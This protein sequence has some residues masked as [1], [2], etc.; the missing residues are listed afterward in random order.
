MPRHI[1]LDIAPATA[2]HC[3]ASE[4]HILNP[5]AR[6]PKL[7]LNPCWC[8]QFEQ[9][10]TWDDARPQRLPECLAAEKGASE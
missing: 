3:L 6:C 7:R 2:T 9:A 5:N 10:P 8:A 1:R 4:A